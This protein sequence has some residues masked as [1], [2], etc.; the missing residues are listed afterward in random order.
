MQHISLNASLDALQEKYEGIVHI[1]RE[2]LRLNLLRFSLSHDGTV[3]L[4]G[5]HKD[6]PDD[7]VLTF[8][9]TLDHTSPSLTLHGKT[10]IQLHSFRL[11]LRCILSLQ[12]T[13]R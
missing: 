5:M 2:E 9:T 7:P 11:L 8:E 4:T 13:N 10:T 3:T 1:E 12:N 6:A